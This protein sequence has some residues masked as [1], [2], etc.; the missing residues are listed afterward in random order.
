MI[1]HFSGAVRPDAL[2][3][4]L[5]G[6][7]GR[8]GIYGSRDARFSSTIRATRFAFSVLIKN[9]AWGP[10]WRSHLGTFPSSCEILI[11]M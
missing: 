3:R 4:K 7:E 10:E 1:R 2:S 8:R 11:E 9:P 6:R 5:E